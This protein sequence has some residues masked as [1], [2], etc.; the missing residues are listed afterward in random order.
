MPYS[1]GMDENSP[2][3][4]GQR[5][6]YPLAGERIGPAWRAAWTALCRAGQPGWLDGDTLAATMTAAVDIEDKTARGL[7]AKGAAAEVL[8]VRYRRGGKPVR[9]RAQYRVART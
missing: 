7:L 9:L 5:G 4:F 1:E 3:N 6:A 8:E 2:P